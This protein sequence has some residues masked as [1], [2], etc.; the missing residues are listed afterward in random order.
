M[1]RAIFAL[2]A[3]VAGVTAWWLM[4]GVP[5]PVADAHD[6]ALSAPCVPR[7]A[8]A[9]SSADSVR[10]DEYVLK[11]RSRFSKAITCGSERRRRGI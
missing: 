8:A 3:L 10:V 7:Y 9:R 1:S 4:A 2:L 5:R 11:P 6:N